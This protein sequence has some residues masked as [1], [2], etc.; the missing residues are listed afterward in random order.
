MAQKMGGMLKLPPRTYVERTES[1]AGLFYHS[2]IFIDF[3]S[4]ILFMIKASNENI[5]TKMGSL[6]LPHNYGSQWSL[7]VSSIA[8]LVFLE[9]AAMPCQQCVATAASF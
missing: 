5:A 2:T 6:H 7:T 8:S 9:Q 3:P 1:T 4:F